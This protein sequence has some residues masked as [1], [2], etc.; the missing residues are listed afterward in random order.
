MDAPPLDND[1]DYLAEPRLLMGRDGEALAVLVK[2]TFEVWEQQAE[3]APS[4]R[5]RPVRSADEPWGQPDVSSI[6]YP[7]DLCLHKPG[8][9]VVVVAS[10]HAPH[11]QPVPSFDASVKV[12]ALE[13]A[14]RVFGLRVWEGRGS[15]L[16][17][18]K[19]TTGCAVRYDF[20]WGGSDFSDPSA[21]VEEARNPVGRGVVRDRAALTHQEAPCIEDPFRLIGS[22]DTAPE[23][24]GLGAIGRHWMPRRQYLGTYDLAW[25]ENLAPLL[26]QDFD[27]RANLCAT[28]GLTATTP[29][30]GG[31]TVGLLNL[32]PGGGAVSFALP[33]VRPVVRCQREGQSPEEQRPFLDTVLI[34]THD[35]EPKAVVEMVW[36][37]VFPPPR[38]MKQVVLE[39]EEDA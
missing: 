5:Q 8:T 2:A 38:R 22:A 16:S 23:P 3:L 33:R 35:T 12:G 19:P 32:T 28:P 36:R 31:E 18:P 13:R 37:A 27:D 21:P 7:S 20:A 6:R 30:A 4:G 34:D 15:G 1:T 24:G 11:G 10:A 29:L 39:V 14:V 26:P 25:Q 17:S 9:D